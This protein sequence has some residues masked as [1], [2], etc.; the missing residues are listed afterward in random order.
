MLSYITIYNSIAAYINV[1][2]VCPVSKKHHIC[3]MSKQHLNGNWESAK[4][5]TAEFKSS[6]T[7]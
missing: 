3:D 4:L 7:C 5:Y 6:F 1:N 2:S